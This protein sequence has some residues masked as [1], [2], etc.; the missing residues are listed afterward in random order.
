MGECPILGNLLSCSFCEKSQKQVKKLIAGPGVYICDLCICG[1]HAVIA[2]PGRTAS[3]P[4]ATIQAN[5]EGGAEQC[6]FCGKHRH[7]V[8]AIASAGDARICSRRK[9]MGMTDFPSPGN[10]LEL[11]FEKWDKSTLRQFSTAVLG[12]DKYGIWVTTDADSVVTWPDG[13]KGR[14]PNV[15]LTFVPTGSEW[16]TVTWAAAANGEMSRSVYGNISLPPAFERQQVR[17]VDLDLDVVGSPDGKLTVVDWEDF[18]SNSAAMS[19]PDEVRDGAV[20]AANRLLDA[21]TE[22][23]E[24]YCSVAD[25]WFRRWRSG[26]L[27]LIDAQPRTSDTRRHFRLD[28]RRDRRNNPA[29][30]GGY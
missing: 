22:G 16:W 5:D 19:Y 23:I 20:Q 17:L 3:T 7:Q 26:Q 6:S 13:S 1:A 25:L 9:G 11:R 18:A 30:I 15:G 21:L 28:G 12:V 8:A 24:P 14:L 4:I 2:E 27:H 29:Q 10:R